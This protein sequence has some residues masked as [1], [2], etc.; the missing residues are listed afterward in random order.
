MYG[1]PP[2]GYR[3]PPDVKA[4]VI[5]ALAEFTTVHF[6]LHTEQ[7]LN[8]NSAQVLGSLEEALAIFMANSARVSFRL[9]NKKRHA[10]VH[11]DHF[12]TA[13]SKSNAYKIG[14]YDRLF[15]IMAEDVNTFWDIRFYAPN[16]YWTDLDLAQMRGCCRRYGGARLTDMTVQVEMDDNYTSG[17]GLSEDV[18]EENSHVTRFWPNYRSTY[19]NMG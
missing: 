9:G 3:I 1:E 12:L 17:T 4:T 8:C 2:E 19:R 5:Q 15:S 16:S 6:H 7:L 14:T 10:I 11:F 13:W 18:T